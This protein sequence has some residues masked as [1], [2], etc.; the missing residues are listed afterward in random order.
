MTEL[1]RLEPANQ[2]VLADLTELVDSR[3]QDWDR[4]QRQA[5]K[6][7]LKN[8]RGWASQELGID[9]SRQVDPDFSFPKPQK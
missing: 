5:V 7:H 1:D 6:Y 4:F 9:L 2:A 8:A 3:C